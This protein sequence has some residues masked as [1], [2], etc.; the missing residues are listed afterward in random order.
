M[1]SLRHDPPGPGPLNRQLAVDIQKFT[2]ALRRLRQLVV[3]H[4]PVS[5]RAP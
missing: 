4:P 1:Q 3:A 2:D 5:R